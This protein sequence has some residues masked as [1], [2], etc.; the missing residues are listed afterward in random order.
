MVR[1]K[2]LD[3]KSSE[4]DDMNCEEAFVRLGPRRTWM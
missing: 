4:D 2:G 3:A 1:P